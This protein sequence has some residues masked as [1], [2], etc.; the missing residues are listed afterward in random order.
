[1]SPVRSVSYVSGRSFDN[2]SPPSTNVRI[3]G[4]RDGTGLGDVL[5]QWG[6]RRGLLFGLEQ[7]F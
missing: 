5:P 4:L 1:M 3:I 2:Q 6:P 7:S